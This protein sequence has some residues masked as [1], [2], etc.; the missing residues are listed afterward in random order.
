MSARAGPGGAAPGT[1]AVLAVGVLLMCG[2]GLDV[3]LYALG[4][5]ERD[6][7]EVGADSAEPITAVWVEEGDAVEAG[8]RLLGQDPARAEAQLG[9]VRAELAAA[10]AR[11]D[12]AVNGPRPQA[13]ARAEAAL[14]AARSAVD[15]ARAE[16][17]RER[18]LVQRSY[19]SQNDLDVL[20]GRLDQARAQRREAAA[21]LDEVREG[22]RAEQLAQARAAV[23]A[24]L[25]RE[26]EL[27][28]QVERTEVRAPLAG[29]VEALPLEMGERPGLGQTV[30]VLRALGPTYARVYLPEP[31]R[32]VLDVG[33]RAEVRVDGVAD[34]LA[35][36]VRWISSEAAF[37]PYFALTQH[38]RSRLAYLAEVVLED[39][40]AAGLPVGIPVEVR[41]ADG[42]P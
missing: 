8:Q 32:R 1:R 20:Q 36:H 5:L 26:R 17:V 42:A 6:R 41:A 2:C 23:E 11:L 10:R 31:M 40:N 29:T 18:S 33:Q 39:Q 9:Q 30:V 12:E 37:T 28:L 24:A 15:T 25:A 21:A 4:T 19:G 35:A 27:Q 22:T 38:D 14:A 3:P 16:M 13:L 7:I 34:P